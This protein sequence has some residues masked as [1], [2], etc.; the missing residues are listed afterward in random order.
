MSALVL[1]IETTGEDWASMDAT[2][3]EMLTR[4]LRR[5][6]FDDDEYEKAVDDVKNGLGFSP[7]TGFIVALGVWDLD[8]KKGAVYYQAPGQNIA[9]QEEDGIIY[10]QLT[11]K[12]ILEQFWKVAEKYTDVITFNGRAF[13]APYII[14]RSAVHHIRP[15]KNL[16]PSRY[17][18]YLKPTDLK[19]I[20][21]MD[22]LSFYGSVRKKGSLHLWCRAFGIESPK[23]G[24]VSGDDVAGLFKAGKCLEIA[25]YN[26]GDL[27]ATG[28]LYKR[29]KESFDI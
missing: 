19:H 16:M 22:Q 2:T 8:R 12:E 29:W 6:S 27:I 1:D 4:W 10:K 7:L 25:K 13:D 24:G 26:V 14:A 18:T 20:D 3:Q 15:T 5:E 23:T 28:E 17:L 21:L 11:E 9:E